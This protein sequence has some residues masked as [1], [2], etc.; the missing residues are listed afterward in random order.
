MISSSSSSSPQVCLVMFVAI[1]DDIYAV[2]FVLILGLLLI[3]PGRVL[4]PLWF[5]VG[6]VL[7]VLLLWRYALLLGLPPLFCGS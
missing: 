3:V 2:V 5:P 1:R 6:I 7:A 4:R